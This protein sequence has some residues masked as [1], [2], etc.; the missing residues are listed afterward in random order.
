M[1]RQ[2]IV[3]FV[4]SSDKA[5]MKNRRNVWK[6]LRHLQH[7]LTTTTTTAIITT[8]TSA[9]HEVRLGDNSLYCIRL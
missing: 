2:K 7:V 5:V 8:T 4:A 9:T 6:A 1:F 3:I